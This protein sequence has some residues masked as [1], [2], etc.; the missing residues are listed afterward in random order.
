MDVWAWVGHTGPVGAGKHPELTVC[1]CR[2]PVLA[3]TVSEPAQLTLLS[4]V[5]RT[6]TLVLSTVLY[7]GPS[8]AMTQAI[9]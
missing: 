1:L 6:A 3:Q 7:K 8:V 4:A 9:L 2:A 5:Q